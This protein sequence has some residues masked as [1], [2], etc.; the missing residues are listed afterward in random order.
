MK[1]FSLLDFKN[2]F[3]LAIGLAFSFMCGA[4][5]TGVSL[6]IGS[7]TNAFSPTNT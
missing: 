1:F 6:V 3:Y 7:V 4:L 5:Q 2:K